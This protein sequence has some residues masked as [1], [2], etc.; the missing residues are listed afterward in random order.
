MVLIIDADAYLAGLDAALATRSV[1]ARLAVYSAAQDGRDAAQRKVLVRT[2][3]TRRSGAVHATNTAGRSSAQIVFSRAA[4]WVEFGT[5]PHLIVP[6]QAGKALRFKSGGSV[7]FT[8]RVHHPGT[9]PA[10]FLRPAL[11]EVRV[12]YWPA[13][14]KQIR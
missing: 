5:A 4:V 10:P 8:R 11:E 12:T 9:R 6:R 7:V 13:R 1:A 3:A 2:G 14:A